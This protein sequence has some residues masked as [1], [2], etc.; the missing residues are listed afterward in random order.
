[1]ALPMRGGQAPIGHELEAA[2]TCRGSAAEHM[3]V[4]PSKDS[5]PLTTKQAQ[6]SEKVVFGGGSRC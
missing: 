2:P 6:A 1:M 5:P 3:A 4:V